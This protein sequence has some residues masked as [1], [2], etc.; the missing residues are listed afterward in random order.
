MLFSIRAFASS[1]SASRS[2]RMIC[3]AVCRFLGIFASPSLDPRTL[4]GPI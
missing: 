1:T 4:A 2:V 3:S